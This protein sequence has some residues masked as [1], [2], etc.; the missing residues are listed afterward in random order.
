MNWGAGRMNPRAGRNAGFTRIARSESTESE[1]QSRRSALSCDRWQ[2]RAYAC[3]RCFAFAATTEPRTADAQLLAPRARMRRIVHASPDAENPDAYKSA[4]CRCPRG[5]A[6]PGPRADRPMIRARWLAHEC[7]NRCGYT[8]FHT[9]CCLR[10]LLQAQPARHSASAVCPPRPC[11]S[12][13]PSSGL[14]PAR[15]NAAS[16]VTCLRRRPARCAS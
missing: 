8:R 7:R 15:V 11:T 9:P 16:A 6:I 13:S 10:A 1:R 14:I 4:S 2:P 12:G 5:R 3:E